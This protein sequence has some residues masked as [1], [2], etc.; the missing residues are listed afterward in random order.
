MARRPTKA[1]P[2]PDRMKMTEGRNEPSQR[3]TVGRAGAVRVSNKAKDAGPPPASKPVRE[4]P[5][6]ILRKTATALAASHIEDLSRKGAPDALLARAVADDV[7]TMA[8][9]LLN[10]PLEMVGPLMRS[11]VLFVDKAQALATQRKLLAAAEAKS[12]GG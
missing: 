7:I 2:P 1:P 9:K 8:L 10:I 12:S 5:V 6:A 4:T 3:P 11:E